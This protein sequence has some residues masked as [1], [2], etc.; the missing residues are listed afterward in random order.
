VGRPFRRVKHHQLDRGPVPG[1]RA[2]NGPVR[3]QG[4]L[5]ENYSIAMLK[6]PENSL[7]ERDDIADLFQKR[8]ITAFEIKSTQN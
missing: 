6:P 5:R 7:L 3:S 1:A 8:P 2:A 4:T